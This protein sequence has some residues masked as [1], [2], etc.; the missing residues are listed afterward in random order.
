VLHPFDFNHPETRAVV[1]HEPDVMMAT[2]RRLLLEAAADRTLVMTSH[3]PF[4]GLGYVRS[5]GRAWEWTAY[6]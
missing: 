1:D 6:V 4:P 3:C 5:R 2:R